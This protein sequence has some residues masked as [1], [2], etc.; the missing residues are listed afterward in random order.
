M[1]DPNA[2]HLGRTES[3]PSREAPEKMQA[4]I[5]RHG[6]F[7][8]LTAVLLAQLLLLS[9]QISGP[10]PAQDSGNHRVPL[11]RVWMV[12]MLH[13]FQA[14][15]GTTVNATAGTWDRVR[16]LWSTEQ[17][18]RQLKAQLIAAQSQVRQLSEKGA[19]DDRL[20][21]LLDLKQHLPFNTVAA[22]VI[23]TSPGESSNAVFIDKGSD[24]GLTT[25]MA[26]LTPEGI[27]GKVIAVFP[28]TAQVLLITDPSSGVGCILDRTRVQ[29]VLKGESRGLCRLQYIMNE[30]PVEDGDQVI[31]SGLDQIYPKGLPVGIVTSVG[32]GNIYKTIVVRPAAQLDRLED[33]LV[34]ARP[35]PV[36]QQVFSLPPSRRK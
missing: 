5:L 9:F 22:E 1:Y 10:A 35:A 4:F 2:R 20:R 34:A 13:P 26:V 21:A 15:L 36:E 18:N 25:D 16:G 28:Y 27:A 11:F 23:A 19:E 17:E 7:F 12:A 32:E 33:V 30:E 6:A 14:S 3:P 8:V 24:A 29:G 31:T